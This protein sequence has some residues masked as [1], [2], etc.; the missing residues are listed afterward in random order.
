MKRFFLLFFLI[1]KISLVFG[2]DYSKI[3]NQS[4]TVPSKLKTPI[5]IGQYLAQNLTSPT[6]KARAIY[7][8]ITQNIRYDLKQLN[9]NKVYANTQ[10]ILNEVLNNRQGVCQHYSELFHACCQ[11]VGLQTYVI[12]GYTSQ[13]GKV[14]VIGHAWNA[15]KIDNKFYNIDVTWAAGHLENGKYKQEFN[16]QYFLVSPSEFIKT[17]IPYDPIWQFLSNP[18]T[19]KDF[20]DGN[21][22]K[23]KIASNFNYNDSIQALSSQNQLVK[24]VN[25]NRRIKKCGVTTTLIRNRVAYNQQIIVNE[26][27]NYTVDMFNKAVEVYNNYVLQKNKQFQKT[28]LPDEQILG[29]LSAVHQYIDNANSTL[30]FLTADNADL[31][32][33]IAELQ[34]SIDNLTNDLKKEDTF[35]KK[36]ISTWKPFRMALFSTV[37]F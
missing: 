33:R 23:M 3:D 29:F 34:I 31:N 11:S 27:Y 21:F 37:R 4:K 28:S 30:R 13:N 24:S 26:K 8:W 17:H 10:E 16:D 15:I 18:I 32:N 6:D 7:Y 9:S 12:S 5:E 2:I 19:H 20:E 35:V 1:T 25:E 36:Y 14:D 22:E